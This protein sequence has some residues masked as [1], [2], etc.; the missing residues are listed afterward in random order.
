MGPDFPRS[1]ERGIISSGYWGEK[2]SHGFEGQNLPWSLTGGGESLPNILVIRGLCW[3][4]ESPLFGR[5]QDLWVIEGG[6]PRTLASTISRVI[7]GGL[8]ESSGELS[9]VPQVRLPEAGSCAAILSVECQLG[10]SAGVSGG[11]GVGICKPNRLIPQSPK[12]D[13]GTSS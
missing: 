4:L 9:P 10:L 2:I 12:M 11:G 5:R 3:S 13:P 6:L 1:F 7:N 8:P